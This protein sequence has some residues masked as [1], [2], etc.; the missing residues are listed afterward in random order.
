[1]PQDTR[2]RSQ[3]QAVDLNVT[4]PQLNPERR[5]MT[6][7]GYDS[8]V[9][10]ARALADA[11]AGGSQFYE[12]HLERKNIE[13]RKTAV[14]EA[15]GGQSRREEEKNIAY[16]RAWDTLDDERALQKSSDELPAYLREN[17]A[18]DMDEEGRQALINQYMEDQF[19]GLDSPEEQRGYDRDRLTLS[20]G[21]LK[22]EATELARY[23]IID[24]ELTRAG[25]NSET[26]AAAQG[27]YDD[28]GTLDYEALMERT[29]QFNEGPDRF[30][31]FWS[32]V[33]DIA[34]DNNDMSV[35]DNIP[36][37]FQNGD[38][39]MKNT[40]EFLAQFDKL[41]A[42]VQAGIN[43]ADKDATEK[44]NTM[45]QSELAAQHSALKAR[46]A[47]GDAGIVEDIIAAGRPGPNG[48]P[49][50]LKRAQQESLFDTVIKQQ[51]T[52]G[53]NS[54][55]AATFGAGQM[56]ASAKQADY[57][58]GH[59]TY[60]AA[61]RKLLLEETPDMDPEELE[62]ALLTLSIERS[63]VN[64]RLPS[65]LKDQLMVSPRATMRF[66]KAAELAHR[67]EAQQPGF[68]DQE[69][70]DKQ[71]AMLHGYN[72]LLGES[73]NE[74][75]ALERLDE[76]DPGRAKSSKEM[77][78][79]IDE[80]SEDALTGLLEDRF[81]PFDYDSTPRLEKRVRKQVELYVGMGFD[82]DEA[83]R[84]AETAIR[85]RSTRVG[86]HL[87]ATDA[88]WGSNPEGVYEWAIAHAAAERMLEDTDSIRITPHPTRG[89]TVL[90]RDHDSIL[91]GAGQ[92][93][94][95]TD[96]LTGYN[97][98]M[99][100]TK[101]HILDAA[102]PDVYKQAEQRAYARMFPDNPWSEPGM[103]SSIMQRQRR[104]WANMAD[105]D[106]QRLIRQEMT[107][108]E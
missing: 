36:D 18:S 39:T 71:A 6:A 57:D 45:F 108:N 89:D 55:L 70:N 21:L 40:P 90:I 54:S 5:F 107:I 46:A 104:Q 80:V 68:L 11:F 24:S 9:R 58:L 73:G 25:Q 52:A 81:G 15:G 51:A 30:A 69:L 101:D 72:L 17:G 27:Q 38:P 29:K 94:K 37:K 75:M 60:I 16:H 31:A 41:R 83:A 26:A 48:E 47:E 43:A 23:R 22:L 79:E 74:Q 32:I 97:A 67:I 84:A 106:K 98:H 2:R 4:K 103:R 85:K 53:V 3:R 93:I 96:L 63:V 44:F 59:D 99:G 77:I 64:N 87:Y 100:I 88:G 20:D 14:E 34:V 82:P 7:R 76:F 102:A 56:G 35:L 12:Q 92:Q 8:G 95:I 42:S 10:T 1:M 49:P 28:A 66:P 62:D 105:T 65:V 78:E 86:D 91:P 50:L 33:G 13:A 61:S 19:A